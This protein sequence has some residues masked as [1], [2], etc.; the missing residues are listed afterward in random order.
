MKGIT[1]KNVFVVVLKGKREDVIDS[2]IEQLLR[3][4]TLWRRAKEK[5]MDLEFVFEFV[6]PSDSNIRVEKG[7]H[8]KVH[9]IVGTRKLTDDNNLDSDAYNFSG[10]D[11]D[12]QSV[13]AA[14]T[15]ADFA[16]QYGVGLDT[17][18]KSTCTA[19]PLGVE[20]SDTSTN[21]SLPDEIVN[22]VNESIVSIDHSRTS[23]SSPTEFLSSDRDIMFVKNGSAETVSAKSG[24]S[25]RGISTESRNRVSNTGNTEDLSTTQQMT[26]E[27]TETGIGTELQSGRE[28][29]DAVSEDNAVN[30]SGDSTEP[31][32]IFFFLD[33][34][35]IFVKNG[36]AETVS[37]KNGVSH[38]GISTESRNR[39][40]NTGNV[41]VE[42]IKTQEG[43]GE[44]EE[45]SADTEKGEEDVKSVATEE[46]EG[47]G[48][49]TDTEGEGESTDTE[50]EGESTDTEEG[51]ESVSTEER[52]GEKECTDTEGEEAV[53]ESA[54][55]ATEDQLG[56]TASPVC[57]PHIGNTGMEQEVSKFCNRS[58]A[59][60]YTV[61][62]LENKQDMSRIRHRQGGGRLITNEW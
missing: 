12:G 38:R 28:S 54:D 57:Q 55:T 1:L 26:A 48:E 14:F 16:K 15:M 32:A 23:H 18:D 11:A 17:P 53:E 13:L 19:M 49:S 6:N 20:V 52:E 24:V 41:E 3:I 62:Y 9:G 7:V 37:A 33:R 36:S 27:S 21:Q 43:D 31:P 22:Q 51:E 40:S 61:H 50:G 39:V 58:E 35:M 59:S 46:E 47:E 60:S 2:Y 56:S 25:H 10:L 30:H 45:D 8:H 34:D 5:E 4:I 44:G 29:T 42:S